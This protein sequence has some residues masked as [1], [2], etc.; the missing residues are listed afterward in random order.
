MKSRYDYF[1]DLFL[2]DKKLFEQ[3][4]TSDIILISELPY[5]I[6]NDIILKRFK[7]YKEEKKHKEELLKK[8]EKKQKQLESKLKKIKQK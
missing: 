4:S 8:Q 2:T 7:E 3:W 1:L 6:Y 5:P